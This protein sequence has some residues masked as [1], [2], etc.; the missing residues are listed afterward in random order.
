MFSTVSFRRWLLVGACR[1]VHAFG[2]RPTGAARPYRCPGR[3]CS[4]S[5][6]SSFPIAVISRV[7]V[8]S[9]IL[10][11]LC[12]CGAPGSDKVFSK[13]SPKA[14]ADSARRA[15]AAPPPAPAQALELQRY[16]GYYKRDDNSAQF[17]PC[18]TKRLLEL[19]GSWQGRSSLQDRYRWNS[20]WV[21]RPMF[22]VFIGAIVTDT[23]SVQQRGVPED[24][25]P[26]GP[27]TRF[28][29]TAVES[30]RTWLTGDCNG[31]RIP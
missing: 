6:T 2:Q 11:A 17:Q 15:A 23:P 29:I 27:R 13:A 9:L 8:K 1:F 21:G 7:A 19:T 31:M 18:G 4:R 26:P 3:S 28:Y 14:A 5:F 16:S 22:G 30:L 25:A 24:T 12:G 10:C 20:I